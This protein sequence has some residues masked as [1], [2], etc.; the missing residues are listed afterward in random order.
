MGVPKETRFVGGSS[1]NHIYHVSSFVFIVIKHTKCRLYRLDHFQ[2]RSSVVSS[3]FVLLCVRPHPPFTR[4]FTFLKT[5]M[6]SPLNTKSFPSPQPLATTLLL[7][8]S[9]K[10]ITPGTSYKQDPTLVSDFFHLA[11]CPQGSS[12][13]RPSFLQLSNIPFAYRSHWFTHSSVDGRLDYLPLIE[14]YSSQPASHV[15]CSP[16][17]RSL[18]LTSAILWLRKGSMER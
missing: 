4:R 17:Y 3:A 1:G 18:I 14:S 16:T 6:R 13:F 8:V 15:R 11:L 10:L 2:V 9:M 5:E 7:S 12:M